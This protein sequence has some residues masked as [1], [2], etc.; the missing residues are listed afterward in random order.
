MRH[1]VGRAGLVAQGSERLPRVRVAAL[2]IEGERVL[3]VRHRKDGAEYHLLPGGG[4]EFGE[5][6]A[7][8]LVREVA[9]ETGLH[10]QVGDPVLVSDTISPD[11][12]RHVVNITFLCTAP[13]RQDDLLVPDDR[14]IGVEWLDAATLRTS[15]LRPPIQDE[16]A[17]ILDSGE[18]PGCRYLGSL[19]VEEPT[20]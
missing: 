4:V 16:V 19:F 3:T 6:L 2:V 8:A 12:S 10:V 9:E 7:N 13:Q 11:G 1:V 15:D 5:S 18:F 14:V 17:S 20:R